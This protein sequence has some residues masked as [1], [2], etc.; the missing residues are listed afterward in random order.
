MEVN[1]SAETRQKVV[2]WV[3]A[4]TKDINTGL[5][6][7]EET[8]YKPNVLQIFRQNATR[9]D[10][11][12]KV[13]QQLRLY[14]RYY[15]NPS[16]E[17]HKDEDAAPE[18]PAT[19]TMPGIPGNIE[20]K[21]QSD[22]YPAEIKKLLQLYSDSYKAR[23]IAHNKLK[24]SGNG[25]SPE[26]TTKRKEILRFID[27]ESA[28]QD[29]YW[30]AFEAYEANGTL[31]GENIFTANYEPEPEAEPEEKVFVLETTMKG[32]KKQQDGWRIKIMKAENRL[33]YQSDKKQDKMNPIPAGP[34][35]IIIEKRIV[36]LKAEKLQIDTEIANLK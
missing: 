34:K 7:L 36:R 29:A 12:A 9:A 25:N 15:A 26:E 1:Q 6:L 20:K 16:A 23:S 27:T 8:G 10:I 3:N 33:N 22:E 31:P 11:P 13:E 32:L 4:K 17:I 14:L 35:R 2:R 19:E 28:K 18:Q 5:E 30:F 24:A 21:L